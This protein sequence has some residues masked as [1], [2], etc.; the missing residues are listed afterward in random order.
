MLQIGPL[1]VFLDSREIRAKGEPLHIGSRAFDILELLIRADGALVSK[2]EIMRRVWPRTIVHENNLQ[3]HVAAL[4]KALAEDRDLL[5]TVPGRGYRLLTART[6]AKPRSGPAGA[7]GLRQRLPVCSSTLVG[8]EKSILEIVDSLDAVKIVTLVGAGGIGKTRMAVEVAARAA[9]RF[10]D[11]AVFVPLASISDPRSVIDAVADALGVA[12][13]GARLSLGDV[14]ARLSTRRALLVLD[15]CEHLIDSAARVAT[16]VAAASDDLR[17]IATSREALRVPG[18]RLYQV[19][20]L[21]VPDEADPYGEILRASAVQLFIAR[22]RAADPHF[23]ADERA[24]RLTAA[25][26][27]RLDGL[28]LAIELAAARAAVLGVEVLAD[29][30]DDHFRMLAG[31]FRTALPRHQT[32]KATLDW[33]YR[34]LSESE[35]ML[36]RW[37]G[38]FV[39]GFSLDGALHL[40]K[41]RGLSQGETL[42][43]LSGLVSKSLVIRES[44]E[45]AARYRL[46]ATTRAYA[47][48]KLEDDGEH[49]EAA[50]AHASYSREKV[51]QGPRSRAAKA[52]A[53]DRLL[54]C[55]LNS[56]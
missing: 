22:A 14:A 31:G 56:A 21:D 19:Q 53:R 13:P 10:E 3:V 34:L 32:L 48:Q 39:H 52:L 5:R 20:P 43:A 30:L 6:M 26:C 25:V 50:L 37:L 44:V 47:L 18:E 29:Y 24:L 12:M 16:A 17:V 35:R 42:D 49:K 51:S 8:R 1:H 54:P 4:R 15:N 38:V 45:T 55:M 33:S 46:L 9:G 2:D 7:A 40:G 23:L 27:R 28:P 36:L 11:G 41:A